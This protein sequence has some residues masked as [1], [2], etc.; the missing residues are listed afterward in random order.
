[1]NT[2]NTEYRSLGHC[3]FCNE[4]IFGTHYNKKQAH[5]RFCKLNPDRERN[6]SQ[7]KSAGKKGNEVSYQNNK[8]KYDKANEKHEHKF[9]CKKCG[10]EYTLY[11]TDTEFNTGNYPK[12]CSSKCSHSRIHTAE[13][14]KKVSETLHKKRP[15]IC[16][17][18]NKEFD[19]N[20]VNIKNTLC[21]ECYIQK[22]GHPRIARKQVI[23]KN[24]RKIRIKIC[25]NAVL[26]EV[27]CKNCHTHIYCKTTD[28][29]YCYECAK[30][31]NKRVHQLYDCNGK[32]LLSNDTKI[33]IS[34]LIQKRVKDGTHVGWKI[35]P[36]ASYPEKFWMKVLQNNNIKYEFNFYIN[37]RSL[38]LSDSS[39]YFLDFKL[40]KNIDLE[41]DGKQHTYKDRKESDIRRDEILSKNGWTIYRIPWNEINSESGKNK[42]KEKITKFLNFY[43]NFNG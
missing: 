25:N 26:H 21:N 19:H 12:C 30:K 10:N 22:Y 29:V 20:G 17:V 8:A 39:G 7:I 38:G 16:P 23:D 11:L 36:I 13:M 34:Q 18:C 37:K 41:I 27:E 40:D 6:L 5:Q 43:N 15:H 33:K 35:R 1:M 28:D 32:K 2:K 42:M 3:I 31:L 4:E 14:N 24:G 9:I